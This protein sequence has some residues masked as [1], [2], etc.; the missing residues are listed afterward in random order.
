MILERII[1]QFLT[2]QRRYTAVVKKAPGSTVAKSKEAQAEYAFFV[3]FK[4]KPG[5]GV[6]PTDTQ[7]FNELANIVSENS[8]VGKSSKYANG[9][10][11]YAVSNRLKESDNRLLFN[12]WIYDRTVW[13]SITADRPTTGG[14]IPDS[15][16]IIAPRS[17]PYSVGR[18]QLFPI[19]YVES[20]STIIPTPEQKKEIAMLQ[21]INTTPVSQETADLGSNV[22]IQQPEIIMPAPSDE[23]EV[24]ADDE[25]VAAE[26]PVENKIKYPVTTDDGLLVYTTAPTDDWVY[27][28]SNNIWY[29]MKKPEFE[30]YWTTDGAS[31]PKYAEIKNKT[32][33]NTLNKLANIT[34]VVDNQK[35][36]DQ[37]V[38][39]VV[40]T[41]KTVKPEEKKIDKTDTL[42]EDFNKC[43][44][45]AKD[46]RLVTTLAPE[47]YFYKYKSVINDNEAAAAKWF[48]A[49]WNKAWGADLKRLRAS[50]NEEIVKN[51]VRINEAATSVYNAITAGN[52]M[53]RP[54][55]ISILNPKN[56]KV[57]N[58]IINWQYM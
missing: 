54:Y 39:S 15:D 10:Y 52:G 38:K 16:V 47:K 42:L 35:I 23:D 33:I 19:Q 25:E 8:S 43:L 53:Y 13:D 51:S 30:Q 46:L 58:F 40:D 28:N 11:V 48:K 12:I 21:T 37:P 18:S 36:S 56:K 34:P 17:N 26:E 27:W 3:R 31:L 22:N 55:T 29:G 24:A 57:T 50:N 4:F 44:E 5:A 1:K 45:I 41:K 7:L 14:D 32:A 9:K 20:R 2:E 6:I 49:A